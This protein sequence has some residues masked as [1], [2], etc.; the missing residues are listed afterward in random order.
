MTPMRTNTARLQAPVT[1]QVRFQKGSVLVEFA[2]I[3]PL[4]LLLLFGVVSFS[5]ALYDKTVLTMATREGARAGAKFVANRTSAIMVSNATAAALQAC[6]NNLISFG[7]NNAPT[8]TCTVHDNI[9]TVT[10]NLNYTGVFIV[11][12]FLISAQSSMRLE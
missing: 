6:Q 3:L 12:D 5:I 1:E 11:S 7:T 8:L 9:L 10:A 2:L 4:F